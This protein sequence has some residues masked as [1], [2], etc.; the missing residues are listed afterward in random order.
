MA[1]AWSILSGTE[2]H[3][4]DGL[5]E[6]VLRSEIQMHKLPADAVNLSVEKDYR[7]SP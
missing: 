4:D 2:I 1:R 7:N 3:F 6:R 5:T